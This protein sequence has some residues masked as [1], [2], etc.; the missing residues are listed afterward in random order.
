MSTDYMSEEKKQEGGALGK[1]AKM[2]CPC[3]CLY[4]NGNKRRKNLGKGKNKILQDN[5]W[6]EIVY[7]RN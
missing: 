5:L 7:D 4:L 3:S 1:A 6:L 2:L